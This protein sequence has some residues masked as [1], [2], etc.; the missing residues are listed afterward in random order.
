MFIVS[1]EALKQMEVVRRQGFFLPPTGPVW[2]SMVV[3]CLPPKQTNIPEMIPKI[4]PSPWTLVAFCSP[5]L[6]L[7]N[8][9]TQLSDL[10]CLR[11]ALDGAEMCLK[12][13]RLAEEASGAELGF[14]EA[15]AL[16]ALEP[17]F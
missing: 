17:S 6:G 16:G 11:H 7:A 14:G 15:L 9:P 13:A 8:R 3:T 5:L 10:G 2:L 12:V 4:N 1:H